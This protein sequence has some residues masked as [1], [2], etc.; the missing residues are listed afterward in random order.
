M[1]SV[2]LKSR[3]Y[4]KHDNGENAPLLAKNRLVADSIQEFK[5]LVEREGSSVRVELTC[6]GYVGT[7]KRLGKKL[8]KLFSECK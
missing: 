8:M 7:I 4:R 5:Q 2:L 1:V 3:D 6:E